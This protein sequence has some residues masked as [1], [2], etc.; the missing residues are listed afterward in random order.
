MSRRYEINIQCTKRVHCGIFQLIP[1]THT[2]AQTHALRSKYIQLYLRRKRNYR[3]KRAPFYMQCFCVYIAFLRRF[4]SHKHVSFCSIR[5]TFLFPT[6]YWCWCLVR[7]VWYV[8]VS[9]NRKRDTHPPNA[10]TH[11]AHI[12][13]CHH[14][15]SFKL[16]KNGKNKVLNKPDR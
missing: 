6:L 15:L 2:H 11:T 14:L 8:S 16:I 1:A 10:H 3:N 4:H 13:W 7:Y 9:H 12:I 5:S